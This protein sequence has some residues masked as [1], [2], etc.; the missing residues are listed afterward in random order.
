MEMEPNQ[1]VSWP[2][3][4]PSG[5]MCGFLVVVIH[6]QQALMEL[7]LGAWHALA[8]LPPRACSL[9]HSQSVTVDGNMPVTA[10]E[11]TCLPEKRVVKWATD[12]SEQPQK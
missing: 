6:Q 11:L 2:Q 5:A 3:G 8:P 1:M 7:P 12:D 4:V 10:M 9:H